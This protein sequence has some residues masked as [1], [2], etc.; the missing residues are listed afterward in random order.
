MRSHARDID[1]P[2]DRRIGLLTVALAILIAVVLARALMLESIRDPFDPAPSFDLGPQP[3]APGAAAG[4]VLDALAMLPAIAIL[5]HRVTHPDFRLRHHASLA[6]AAPLVLWVA[7]SI[8]WSADKFASLVSAT[9][10][11]TALLVLWS[12][13]QLVR[14]WSQFRIIAA[15]AMGLLLAYIAKSGFDRFVEMPALRQVWFANKPAILKQHGW[16]D[17]SYEAHQFELRVLNGQLMGFDASPNTFAAELVLLMTIAAA[18]VIQFMQEDRPPVWAIIPSLAIF[19]GLLCVVLTGCRAAVGTISLTIVLLLI[20][21]FL[22]PT[23]SRSLYAAGIAVFAGGVAFIVQHG[24]RYGTLFHSSLTFRWDYWVGAAR[25]FIAHP[26]LGV[27]WENFG[28]YYPAARVPRAAESIRDPHNF[29]IR[30]FVE[31]GIPGGLIAIGFFARFAWDLCVARDG[32]DELPSPSDAPTTLPSSE[33]APPSS[34]HGQPIPY[35]SSA[36]PMSRPSSSQYQVRMPFV[37]AVVL[38]AVLINIA[39]AIDFTQDGAYVLDELIKRLMFGG[40]L[41]IAAIAGSI[42]RWTN[43]RIDDR[44]APWLATGIALALGV[45]LV[46]NLIEFSLFETGPLFLIA[47]LAGATLGIRTK[48]DTT[49]HSTIAKDNA[50]GRVPLSVPMAALC[51]ATIGWL[52]LLFGIVIP[53]VRAESFAVE[54]ADDIRFGDPAR[55]NEAIVDDA[56]AWQILP[57]NDDYAAQTARAMLYSDGRFPPQTVI[58]WLDR[59][60]ARNP[61]RANYRVAVAH[62]RAELNDPAALDDLQTAVN[63]DPNDV[64]DRLVYARYLVRFNRPA[65]AVEQFRIALIKNDLLDKAEPKRLPQDVIEGIQHEIQS[66]ESAA[67]QPT[68]HP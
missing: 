60:I 33:S 20:L 34:R 28:L 15:L 52:L 3:H 54:G 51:A 48:E 50:K 64:D 18:F 17:G 23:I 47:L 63:L 39:A 46:H 7:A 2:N 9:H 55:I 30:F 62:I 66:A 1:A 27:G 25:V 32:Y 41:L 24:L 12:A 29:L 8:F 31:L 67:T 53:V 61:R 42:D 49:V 45:F 57:F 68:T 21:V 37:A 35:R 59:A 11:I 5:L 38:M 6:L 16:A 14:S 4:L 22:R 43:P 65:Q 26:F 44:P 36:T 10:F 13:V 56:Q 19:A 58:A 40:C